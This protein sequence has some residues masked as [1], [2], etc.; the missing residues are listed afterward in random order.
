[1]DLYDFYATIVDGV[2]QDDDLVSWATA[3]FGKAIHVYGAMPS[4]D[5]PDMTDDVPFVLFGEPMRSCSQSQRRITYACGA[6]MGLSDEDDMVLVPDNAQRPTG[7]ELILDGMRLVR[8][9]VVASLPDGVL[10]DDF[11]E[12]ADVNAVGSEVHGDL[13]FVFIHTLTIG[14]SPME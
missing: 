4:A 3:H 7:L 13:N 9:A 12:H 14:Q 11:E 6:W 1:M 5:F 10:L 8:L 2:A